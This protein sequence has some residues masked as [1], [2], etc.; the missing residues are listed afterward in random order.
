MMV[1]EKKAVLDLLQVSGWYIFREEWK[2]QRNQFSFGTVD[3][4][5]NKKYLINEENIKATGLKAAKDIDAEINDTKNN[6]KIDDWEAGG[7]I[8]IVINKK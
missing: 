2:N 8:K 3:T 4:V 7:A 5:N 6:I 1:T